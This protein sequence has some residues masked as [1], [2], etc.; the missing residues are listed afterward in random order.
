MTS[1]F[2]GKWRI[3]VPRFL[4]SDAGYAGYI[5]GVT[6][7]AV[8]SDTPGKAQNI[9]FILRAEG[10]LCFLLNNDQYVGAKNELDG[11]AILEEVELNDANLSHVDS[12][13]RISTAQNLSGA[14]LFN[15]IFNNA[16]LVPSANGKATNLSNANLQGCGCV[17]QRRRNHP[18]AYRPTI[19]GATEEDTAKVT[20]MGCTKGTK[21]KAT[22]SHINYLCVFVDLIFVPFVYSAGLKL[23]VMFSP[24]SPLSLGG[25]E[26]EK[27][28]H[29]YHSNFGSG[30]KCVGTVQLCV[31]PKCTEATLAAN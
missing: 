13:K 1:T 28:I 14:Q 15:A 18:P 9:A 24:T 19:S 25:N 5:S 3:Y 2:L 20:R 6:G 30:S 23:A 31:Q 29:S 22:K 17:H 4:A 7:F 27:T 21:F 11:F 10:Q 26:H 12:P 8:S 16:H